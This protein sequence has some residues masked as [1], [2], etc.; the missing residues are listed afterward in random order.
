MES[1]TRNSSPQHFGAERILGGICFICLN[2]TEPGVVERSDAGRLAIGEFRGFPRPVLHD[3]TWEF[4]RAGVV[5]R[6]VADLALERWR[7]LVWNIPFNGLAVTAGG[8]DTAAILADDALRLRALALMDETIAIANA[9]GHHLPTAVAL[10]QMKNTE[11]MGNY[12]AFD[13]GRLPGGAPARDRGDLG[14]A[15]PRRAG[16]E[17]AGAAP[18]KALPRVG[19]ARSGP[20]ENEERSP[21]RR[22]RS[23]TGSAKSRSTARRWKNLPG[24]RC[25]CARASAAPA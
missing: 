8:I 25:P 22:S 5:C 3:I 16:R 18:G 14:R 13:P 20:R 21:C 15:A 17:G 1:G 23:L 11:K 9:C 19:R 12:Q 7:K 6:V 10:E 2:R 24:R 4:K